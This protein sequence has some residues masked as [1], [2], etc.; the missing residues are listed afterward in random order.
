MSLRVI[1]HDYCA[2]KSRTHGAAQDSAWHLGG[3][4]VLEPAEDQLLPVLCLQS[5][6]QSDPVSLT[7]GILVDS[8]CPGAWLPHIALVSAQASI[9]FLAL[10][11]QQPPP[12]D[13]WEGGATWLD[14]CPEV[15]IWGP[16]VG[17][18]Y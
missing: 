2:S 14:Q 9:M 18:S 13:P 11:D 17:F 3:D 10:L 1:Q 12:Q 5:V 4:G 8:G 6:C 16:E 7:R 15:C